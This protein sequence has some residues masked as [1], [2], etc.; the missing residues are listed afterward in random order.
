MITR[1]PFHGF[2]PVAIVNRPGTPGLTAPH[3]HL[4]ADSP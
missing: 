1:P 4:P 3:P 2:A